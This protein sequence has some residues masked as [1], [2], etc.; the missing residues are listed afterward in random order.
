MEEGSLIVDLVVPLVVFATAAI[1]TPGPNNIMLMSAGASFGV[2]PVVPHMLGIVVGFGAVLTLACAGLATLFT[3]YP[4]VHQALRFVGA[5]YLLYLAWR[6][7]TSV[8]IDARRASRPLR[9][10]EAAGFQFANPKGVMVA[11]TVATTFMSVGGNAWLETSLI[12]G[13]FLTMT[14]L[15]V[16]VW[17]LFGTAIGRLLHSRRSRRIFN[18]VMAAALVASVAF[19]IR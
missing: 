10:T 15:S 18:L 11:A 2:R 12:V 1:F 8:S 7:A 5:A 13:V 16:V 14:A 9:F 17:T 19:V 6:V 4:Q 3:R